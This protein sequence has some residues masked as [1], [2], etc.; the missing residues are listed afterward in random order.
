M[1]IVPYGTEVFCARPRF[2]SFNDPSDIEVEK[3]Y[4]ISHPGESV[5]IGLSLK[6]RQATYCEIELPAHYHLTPEEAVTTYVKLH[7]ES[8]RQCIKT[9]RAEIKALQSTLPKIAALD[10]TKVKVRGYDRNWTDVCW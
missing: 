6:E 7:I 1:R 3:F 4:V 9:K 2:L 10:P 8:V 5:K